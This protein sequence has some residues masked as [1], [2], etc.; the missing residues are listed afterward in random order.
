MPLVKMRHVF[1][2]EFHTF[3][4]Y[5]NPHRNFY[6]SNFPLG[7]FLYQWGTE[8]PVPFWG[9]VGTEVPVPSVP[10]RLPYQFN[11]QQASLFCLKNIQSG[12]IVATWDI[13]ANYFARCCITGNKAKVHQLIAV[14]R[15]SNND[16]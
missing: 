16:I 1:L 11:R 12:V 8:V 13:F 14:A 2:N 5:K 9:L 15:Q 10:L 7:I 4:S 6:I 3:L